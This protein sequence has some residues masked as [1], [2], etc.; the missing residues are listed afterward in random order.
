MGVFDVP[1]T[2]LIQEIALDLESKFNVPKPA[3]I[4]FVKTGAQ[5]ERAP[6]QSNWYYVRMASILYRI[7]KEG[8]LGVGSLRTYYGGRK[9]RG[10]RPHR[11]R[12]ASGKII[13]FCLQEL[14]KLGFIQKDKNKKG[15][16][17]AGRGHSYLVKK[18]VELGKKLKEEE[19]FLAQKIKGE[20]ARMREA[21]K[22]KAKEVELLISEDKTKFKK[23]PKEERLTRKERKK[24]MAKAKKEARK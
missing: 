3:F 12:K 13:R 11:F 17:I 20:E 24:Q 2:R 16:I 7:F 21:E 14:E 22:A 15:R 19:A 8:P 1:A 4:D 10:V 23:K 6:Q 5:R 18:S 9:S